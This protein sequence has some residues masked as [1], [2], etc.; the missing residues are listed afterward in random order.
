MTKQDHWKK[1]KWPLRE[2]ITLDSVN[3]ISLVNRKKIIL[4]PLHIKLG[5]M[6]QFFK[7]LDK[8]GNCFKYICR[9][10]PGLC[11]KKLKAGIF[12]SL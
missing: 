2:N 7:A 10:F 8:D 6:K 9:S 3:N 1:V 4:P 11:M 5:L 12:D